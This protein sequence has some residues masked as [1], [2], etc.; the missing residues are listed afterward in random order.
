MKTTLSKVKIPSGLKKFTGKQLSDIFYASHNLSIRELF[1]EFSFTDDDWY[2]VQPVVRTDWNIINPPPKYFE[3]IIVSENSNKLVGIVEL[4]R[5]GW[6]SGV[7]VIN[8]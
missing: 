2:Y 4:S 7:Q 5:D 8:S 1:P 6:K 3:T